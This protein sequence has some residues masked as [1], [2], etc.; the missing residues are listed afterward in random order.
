MPRA[1]SAGV[2]PAARLN[3]SPPL[4]PNKFGGNTLRMNAR[5]VSP[6]SK[7]HELDGAGMSALG[8]AEF[9]DEACE[10]HLPAIRF[11]AY[12]AE[13]PSVGRSNAGGEN[14]REEPHFIIAAKHKANAVS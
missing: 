12:F 10:E 11:S 6:G 3:F 1:A 5:N 8:R 7:P 2:H 13:F 4:Q 14:G 9:A